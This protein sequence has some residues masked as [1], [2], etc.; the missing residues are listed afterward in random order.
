MSA[1]DPDDGHIYTGVKHEPSATVL[2]FKRPSTS[3][4]KLKALMLYVLDKM[5]PLTWDQLCWML[6][7]IDSEAFLRTGKSITGCRYIKMP[8]G[9]QP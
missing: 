6:W 1:Q 7:R 8:D 2:Q 5:G 3:E 9:G 4:E